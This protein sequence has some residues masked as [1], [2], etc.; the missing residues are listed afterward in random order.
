MVDSLVRVSRRVG[1]ATDLLATEMQTVPVKDTCYTSL[2]S[3]PSKPK[4]ETR[5]SATRTKLHPGSRSSSNG[6]LREQPEKCSRQPA[7]KTT[8]SRPCGSDKPQ[9]AS[10][11]PEPR[12]A[13]SRTP[14]FTTTQFHVL[15]NSLFKV[16]FNFPSRYLFAIGLGV[17]FSLTW[18]LPRTLSCTPKQL[19][20]REKSA[21][22]DRPSYG[23]ITLYGPW[24]Q[25]RW[26]WTGRLAAKRLSQTPHSA[27]PEWPAV[28][29]W[30]LPVSFAITKGITVVFFSSAY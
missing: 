15:L 29:C 16:L 12:V 4:P 7:K 13:T 30:A 25:S 9:L 21:R 27:R 14:P 23:P 5:G 17:I 24:P 19:D 2:L 1:G 6:S 28:R 22:R 11:Q 26:T 10:R 18:S 8:A 3:Y 20:S